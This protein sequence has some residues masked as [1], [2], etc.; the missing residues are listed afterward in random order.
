[1]ASLHP[2]FLQCGSSSSPGHLKSQIRNEFSPCHSLSTQRHIPSQYTPLPAAASVPTVPRV[3]RAPFPLQPGYAGAGLSLEDYHLVGR[4]PLHSC[5]LQEFPASLGAWTVRD[6]WNA[7]LFWDFKL[8][9]T[10]PKVQSAHLDGEE[11]RED[12]RSRDVATHTAPVTA[13]TPA[14]IKS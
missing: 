10:S 14:F 3:R 6:T 9:A 13:A 7:Y 12:V 1:M 2:T 4:F 5:S 8:P 11:G